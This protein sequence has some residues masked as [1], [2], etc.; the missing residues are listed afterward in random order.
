MNID[1]LEPKRKKLAM[2]IKSSSSPYPPQ[3]PRISEEFF[4][5][6]LIMSVPKP[7]FKYTY[8]F[9]EN[10]ALYYLGT[11]GRRHQYRNPHEI[12][13]VKAFAS[14]VSKGQVSDFVGNPG[15]FLGVGFAVHDRS[16]DSFNAEAKRAVVL[17]AEHIL[18]IAAVKVV[19]NQKVVVVV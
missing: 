6:Q 12:N 3:D 15:T 18:G 11:K 10:G 8:D 13:M 19:G 1:D 17:C 7:S 9:D 5:N 16:V 2:M 4:R 14:S